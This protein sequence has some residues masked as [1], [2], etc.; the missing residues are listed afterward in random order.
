MLD[1][2]TIVGANRRGRFI[3]DDRGLDDVADCDA[4]GQ[5]MG[6]QRNF[7]VCGARG[8]NGPEHSTVDEMN[9]R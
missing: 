7:D 2:Q 6:V 3:V 8:L 9:T 1:D 4:I 5:E